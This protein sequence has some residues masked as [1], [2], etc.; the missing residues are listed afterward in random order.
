MAVTAD[1]VIVEFEARLAKYNADLRS[2]TALFQRSIDQQSRSI[3]RLERDIRSSSGEIS[4][5]LSGLAGAFATAF[6]VQQIAGLIDNFTRLQNS[7]RVAGLEGQQLASVQSQLLDLS[8]RYGVSVNELA[9][10]YG[11]SQQAASDLG[12]GEAQLIQLTEASAQALKI[13]GTSATQA[14]GA[15]LGLTQALASGTVRAEEFNQINEGGLRPLLQVAANAEKYGG[16]V[17]KL[18]QA[19]VDGKLSSQ[20]FYTAILGG[21]AQLE[22]LAN[23]AVLTLAGAF[24][25][26]TS[27]LT[28]YLGEAS[29]A[30]GVTDALSGAI[31]SLADN[32]EVIIPAL[33]VIAVA[34]GGRLAAA[35]LVGGNALRALAAYASIATTSLA[36]TALAARGAGAALLGAFGGPVGLA[37]TA[38]VLGIGYL[39]TRTDEATEA[40]R[41][42]ERQSMS[43]AAA[44]ETEKQIT[45]QLSNAR[46]RERAAII[47]SL[48][49]SRARAAQSIQTA[50]AQIAEAKSALEVARANAQKRVIESTRSTRGAGGGID[51]TISAINRRNNQLNP[52]ESALAQ[53]EDA[54]A[55]AEGRFKGLEA[56]IE[57]ATALPKIAEIASDKKTRNGR[58]GDASGPT[59]EEIDR[60]FN[61]ELTS[62]AQ[63]TLSAQASLAKSAQDRAEFEL[64]S[65]ELSRVQA[66]EGIEAEKDYSDAQK[67]RLKQQVEALAE[68][69]RARIAEARANQ[70]RQEQADLASAIKSGLIEELEYQADN[71]RTLEER[72]ALLI[73]I[74]NAERDYRIQQIDVAL[75]QEG[76]SEAKR[77]ELEAARANAEAERNRRV[78]DANRE[79]M[80]PIDRALDDIDR[81]DPARQ[82][83]QYGVDALKELNGELANAIVY[84]GD[85]GDVLE[86][87]GKRFLAQLL[88]MTF[89][90]LILKPLLQG[91]GNAMTGGLGSVFSIFGR[92]SGG[93]VQRGKPYMVGEAGRELFVPQTNGTIIPNGQLR[94]A[95]GGGQQAIVQL[96]V[97]EG[98]LF[99]PRVRQISGDVSV[100]VVRTA[101][102][103]IVDGAVAETFRRGN[104]PRT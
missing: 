21:S 22:N 89:Q 56:A 42:Q 86:D 67:E 29:A 37:I 77:A 17:A 25:A 68:Q 61:D 41:A 73:D 53:A 39:A 7:L 96:V 83:E 40:A 62:L 44:L 91:I 60:R 57:A 65:V 70:E 8:S 48:Q 76:I 4:S 79:T 23:K 85:L 1:K 59:V 74:A 32:L 71:A 15:L 30:N 51:P 2:S 50:K 102:P 38:L 80:R 18:R 47:A 94:S 87:T 52:A 35:A 64:R 45:D 6:S 104:R 101:A 90:L 27:R 58:G 14:Q 100:Q 95:G 63:Q 19:V 11:K 98:Q 103:T 16:S 97:S 88:E 66:I 36:G 81:L 84:G 72:R 99:E 93:P 10:L 31:K 54:L 43:S 33:T 24:E 9:N 69:E 3:K 5:T 20:E 49:A 46:G 92:A 34:I 13:T 55:K 78:G 26:L 28:V 75:A 12:A 82:A